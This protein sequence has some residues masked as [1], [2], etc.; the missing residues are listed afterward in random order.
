MAVKRENCTVL[1]IDDEP[2]GLQVR[3]L[4]LESVGYKV[5][6]ATTSD[7]GMGLFRLHDV[8]VVVT[9]HLLGRSTAAELAPSMKRLK[10]HVP[11]VSLSGSPDLKEMFRYADRCVGKGE[12]P[13]VLI[14]TLDQ[15]LAQKA[16]EPKPVLPVR[17]TPSPLP[18]QALLAAIVEDSTDAILSK[19]LEGVITSWNY[20][21]ELMYGYTSA[22]MVGAS[23]TKLLPADRPEEVA[24]ILARLNRGER[25]LHFETVRIAKN[26]RKLDVSLTISPIRDDQGRLVG[27]STIARDITEQKTAEGA[28]RKAEKLALA[29]RMAAT[30][31]HEINNP[32][33]AVSNVL[34]L[35]RNA[36][37]LS[38][39]ARKYVDIAYEEL[40]RATEITKLT[41]GM[42][43]SSDRSESVQVNSLLENVLTLYQRK[44]TIL[45]I[46]IDRRYS[47][48]GTVVGIPGELR[49]VFSNLIVN[50]MDALA[51]SGDKLVLRVRRLRRWDTGEQGVRVSI[52]DNGPGIAPEHRLQLFQAFFTTKGEQGT[53]IGLWVS[54]TIVRKHGGTM[55]LHSSVRPGHS[56]TCFSVFLPLGEVARR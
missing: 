13:E 15:I 39:D 48:E 51:A 38:R 2:T 45:G 56:G 8:D 12:G 40:K 10:P 20:A 7:E 34:Y 55:R 27:A 17:S 31:A 5:L 18:T 29:G 30:V 36:V 53:G 52:V 33:E 6:A 49:Q 21:A 3:E 37:E 35:L 19:T 54:R 46:E 25:I 26:G 43:R 22:E 14:A 24:H 4:V 9:D 44:V 32:L 28:L 11:I 16:T 47:D 23:V 41:L 42:Q 50:A 1:L